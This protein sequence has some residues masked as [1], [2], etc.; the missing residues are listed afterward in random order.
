MYDP[1][2]EI[3][4]RNARKWAMFCHLGGLARITFFPFGA[5]LVPFIIWLA[6]QDEHPYIDDQGREAVNFQF[7]MSVLSLTAWL[8]I[9]VLKWIPIIGI[10]R[11]PLYVVPP[12]IWIAAVGGAIYAAMRVNDGDDFR[13]PFSFNICRR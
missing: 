6:K 12:L 2:F 8:T 3:P 9:A 7:T 4:D 1:L 11:F 5:I 13:Y 10:L